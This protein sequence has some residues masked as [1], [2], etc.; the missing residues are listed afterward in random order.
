[1]I[2]YTTARFTLNDNDNPNRYSIPDK[3]LNKP[4]G[5]PTQRLE[6]VGFSY[7]LNPFSFSFADVSD[8]E[9]VFISTKD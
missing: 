2:D 6:M 1:M 8:K 7:N 4:A 5:N 9:N 3:V